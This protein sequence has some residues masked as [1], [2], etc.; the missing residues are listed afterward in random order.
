MWCAAG[1]SSLIMQWSTRDVSQKPSYLGRRKWPGAAAAAPLDLRSLGETRDPP[2][3]CTAACGENIVLWTH[4]TKILAV[5]LIQL[6]TIMVRIYYRG[7][8]ALHNA[9]KCEVWVAEKRLEKKEE[10]SRRKVPCHV[11]IYLFQIVFLIVRNWLIKSWSVIEDK[12]CW[13]SIIWQNA[14]DITI[15]RPSPRHSTTQLSAC[16]TQ[17]KLRIW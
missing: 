1:C 3:H 6:V 4:L 17:Y 9:R 8:E 14:A 10:G 5:L 12:S 13:V 7:W 2:T 11:M 16:N 15:T